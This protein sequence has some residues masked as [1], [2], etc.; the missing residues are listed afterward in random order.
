MSGAIWWWL[1][2]ATPEKFL[3][4]A[5]VRAPDMVSAVRK[6]ARQRYNPGGEVGGWPVREE[7]GLGDPPARFVGR[8]LDK[9]AAAELAREWHGCGLVSTRGFKRQGEVSVI[10]ELDNE[11]Q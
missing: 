3:G 1:S 5:V 7:F 2:F 6:T 4:V 11:G 10:D 8:L 9:D